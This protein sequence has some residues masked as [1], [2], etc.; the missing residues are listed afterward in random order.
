[1]DDFRFHPGVYLRELMVWRDLSAEQL[2]REMRL[3]DRAIV[4]LTHARRS[5]DR[6]TSERLAD[7]FGNS[8][9]FWLDLQAQFD[10]CQHS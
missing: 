1:M 8:A 4:E 9:Q 10:R 5:I 3:P 6:R 2:A 7:Y